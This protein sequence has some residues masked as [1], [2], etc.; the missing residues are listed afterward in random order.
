MAWYQAILPADYTSVQWA[1]CQ[2]GEVS[3]SPDSQESQ[4][5]GFSATH[6]FFITW[7]DRWDFLAMVLGGPR[8][9]KTFQMPWSYSGFPNA[10]ASSCSFRPFGEP[11]VSEVEGDM[12]AQYSNA[13]ATVK[14]ATQEW[15]PPQDYVNGS[16]GTGLPLPTEK[17]SL[18]EPLVVEGYEPSAEFLTVPGANLFWD[19][20]L[21]QVLTEAEAPAFILRTGT[22]TYCM[23]HLPQIPP[24]IIELQGTVNSTAFRSETFGKTFPAETLLFGNPTIKRTFYAGLFVTWEVTYSLTV[25]DVIVDGDHLGWNKFLKNGNVK[26]QAIYYNKLGVGATEW[27][28]YIPADWSAIGLKAG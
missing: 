28:P 27:K 17:I 8:G 16:D 24:S 14:F 6:N 4:D 22:W 9:A 3:Q 18:G 23:K 5:N 26:P 2:G 7:G 11:K 15:V 21:T 19:A 1:E 12:Y 10:V 20:G 13:I 25:K